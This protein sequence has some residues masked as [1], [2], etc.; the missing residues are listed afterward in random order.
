MP[1]IKKEIIIK[2]KMENIKKLSS[3]VL[4]N[5]HGFKFSKT[6]LFYIRLAVEE[7]LVNAIRH[8]NKSNP[9][10]KV[11]FSYCIN[12]EKISITVKDQGKGFNYHNIPRTI[13]DKDILKTSGRGIFLIRTIMDEVRFNSCGNEITM[14]KYLPR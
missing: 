7:A 10:L 8:G 9:K 13:K 12:S 3:K 2:S 1:K 11:K 5:L 14:V 4:R 6:I